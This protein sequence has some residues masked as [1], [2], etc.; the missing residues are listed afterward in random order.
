[1]I[2]IRQANGYRTKQSQMILKVLIENQHRHLAAEQVAESL[3]GQ[4][5]A[6]SKATV[7]RHLDRLV[8]QNLVRKYIVGDGSSACYQYCGD[9]IDRH[10][11]YHL[12]C[13]C[14]GELFHVA[15][16]FLNQLAAHV[17]QEHHFRVDSSKTVLYGVCGHCQQSGKGIVHET[18][19]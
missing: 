8:E 13:V 4:G 18:G 14:C 16:D 1:M 2:G 5:T 3:K 15:C 10:L 17:F 6:V 11:H 9:D 7:Y 19:K 12:K